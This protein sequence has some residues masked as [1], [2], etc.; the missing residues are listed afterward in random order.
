VKVFAPVRR[1]GKRLRDRPGPEA[2]SLAAARAEAAT[3][4]GPGRAPHFVIVGAMKA[5]TT[6]ISANL[7]RHPE[8]HIP[9]KEVRYCSRH[10]GSRPLE[11][12]YAHFDEPL[13]CGEKSPRYMTRLTYMRRLKAVAPDARI[14]VSLRDPA[15][16]LMSHVNMRIER[17]N[18]PPTERITPDYLRQH[19][20]D[21]ADLHEDMIGRGM[22]H[23]QLT[24]NI[25]PLYDRD[26]VWISTVESRTR[27]SVEDSASK[28]N[29]SKN[30]KARDRSGSEQDRMRA[31][32]A[33]LGLQDLDWFDDAN[34]R[35]ENIR[36]Y[37]V[38]VD[39]GARELAAELYAADHE[40]LV[41]DFGPIPW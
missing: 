28:S 17:G 23:H 19:V 35:I 9:R 4:D 26:R 20:L 27:D 32:G 15:A 37:G 16:R 7:D 12:Y 5:G 2:A 22:Y 13:V 10:W 21:V 33:W 8:V 41:R 30:L 29:R 11:W 25:L 38:E 6:S 36:R 3:Y 1:L 14:V 39:P 24:R 31:L 40:L 18:M 34:F